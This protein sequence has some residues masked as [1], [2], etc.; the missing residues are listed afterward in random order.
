MTE[1]VPR[2]H[3]AERRVRV[4]EMLVIIVVIAAVVAMA[5]WFL[6]LA[7]DGIGPGTV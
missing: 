3:R 6:L 1:S 5:I 2:S 4:I 7:S